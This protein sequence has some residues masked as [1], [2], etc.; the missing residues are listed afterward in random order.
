M[1][2]GFIISLLSYFSD[3]E[4]SVLPS[5][6]AVGDNRLAR[7]TITASATVREEVEEDRIHQFALTGSSS[8]YFI[9]PCAYHHNQ[10]ELATSLQM[11]NEIILLMVS[12]Y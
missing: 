6:A 9:E 1:C 10:F 12:Q 7:Q 4:Q 11:H 8:H 2:V 3:S 5:L